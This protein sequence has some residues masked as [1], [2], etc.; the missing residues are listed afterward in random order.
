MT[1][2]PYLI[3]RLAAY[4]TEDQMGSVGWRSDEAQDGRQDVYEVILDGTTMATLLDLLDRSEALRRAVL[5][6]TAHRHAYMPWGGKRDNCACLACAM[7]DL[8]EAQVAVY[9]QRVKVSVR[10]GL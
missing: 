4:I 9:G 5:G 8:E 10:N 2:R 1:E 7:A 6:V 3:E